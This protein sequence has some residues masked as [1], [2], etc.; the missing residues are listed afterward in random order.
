MR[1]IILAPYFDV[2]GISLIFLTIQS[3]IPPFRLLPYSPFFNFHL[4]QTTIMKSPI[5]RVK[6]LIAALMQ[7]FYEEYQNLMKPS[8]TVAESK[9]DPSAKTFYVES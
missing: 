2:T 1:G 8:L 5:T 6:E 9:P 3:V 4:R 7:Y